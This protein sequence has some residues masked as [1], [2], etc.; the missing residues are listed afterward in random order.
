MNLSDFHF[1]LPEELIGQ[2]A[3]EPR[4]SCRLLVVNRSNQSLTHH[5]FRDLIDLLDDRCVLVLNDTK[6]FP[7]RLFG[8]KETGG[9][10]EILLLK[11]TSTDTFECLVRG[12]TKDDQKI[13]FDVSFFG[14]LH[15]V[16]ISTDLPASKAGVEK[17]HSITFNL[18][19]LDLIA[20]I[21]ELGK[22]PLP[23]YIHSDSKEAE[24]REQYQTV[25]AREKGSAAAP[26][27]GLHFTPEIL[28]RLQNKGV[29]IEKL[30]LHV[31]LGTFK[32][33][34]EEQVATKTLH[35]E[36]FTLSQD[37]AKRLNIAKKSGKRIIAVGTTSCRVLETLSDESGNLSGGAGETN[38]FIQPG[39]R[40]KFID[41]MI[42]NFHL[43]STSLLMLVSALV[44]FPNSPA[45][46]AGGPIHFTNFYDSLMD[47]AYAE[48][49]KNKYKFFSFGDAMLIV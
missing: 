38:I 29:Q 26:T 16:V 5:I 37:V 44:S 13:N 14:T 42:T 33:V 32:P 19:G 20:K 21:N 2:Q 18:S 1:E 35:A 47:Q 11:Q 24:L 17:S 8:T 49:I 34:T 48:A 9:K 4:D 46:P 6:V 39:Y 7:A 15:H 25:Y 22:T 3:I 27:A 12:K 28:N 36:S 23:P 41:G 31:G 45:S 30:T 10:I 43:P 40:F